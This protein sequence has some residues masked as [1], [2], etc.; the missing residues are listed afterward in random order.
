MSE[1]SRSVSVTGQ[2]G[3]T[4]PVGDPAAEPGLGQVVVQVLNPVLALVRR[5]R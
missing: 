5:A 3:K 1:Q 4:N 2:T